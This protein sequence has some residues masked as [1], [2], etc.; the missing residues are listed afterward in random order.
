MV[1]EA[2]SPLRGVRITCSSL[3]ATETLSGV[4]PTLNDPNGVVLSIPFISTSETNMFGASS[5]VIGSLMT[6]L[7]PAS[8]MT[9]ELSTWP[10]SVVS[11][12]LT[13]P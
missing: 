9:F 7:L 3:S 5:A 13:L 8:S 1:G 11:S 10:R 2:T 6:S 12:A 4:R